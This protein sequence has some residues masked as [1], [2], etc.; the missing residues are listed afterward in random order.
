MQPPAGGGKP[1]SA[2]KTMVMKILTTRLIMMLTMIMALSMMMIDVFENQRFE[3]L[4]SGRAGN[5]QAVASSNQINHPPWPT[6]T[7]SSLVMIM[8]VMM[9]VMMMR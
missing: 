7:N 8:M 5:R 4:T 1:L 6:K 9:M 2:S 3:Y